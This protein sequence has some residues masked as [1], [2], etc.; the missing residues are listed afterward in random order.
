MI[1]RLFHSPSSTGSP[2]TRGNFFF[3]V[4]RP[5]S[6]YF[7]HPRPELSPF[8][9]PN[10]RGTN[11]PFS[12]YVDGLPEHSSETPLGNSG[13]G[14][15]AMSRSRVRCERWG[16]CARLKLTYSRCG[17]FLVHFDRHT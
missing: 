13:P 4:P 6:G 11:G 7:T 17:L 3:E 14:V 5:S 8:L 9:C 12:R 15:C 16:M 2:V 1:L 10:Y